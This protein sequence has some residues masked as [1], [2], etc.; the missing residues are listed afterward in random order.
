M[1]LKLDIVTP[2]KQ[3]VSTE[4]DEVVIPGLFGE[5][6]ILLG[7][8]PY[9]GLVRYREGQSLERLAVAEGFAEVG[10]ERVTVLAEQCERPEEI[11]VDRAQ[12]ARNRAEE[13]LA[14]ETTEIN[15]ARA[16][17]ALRRAL[18]RIQVA[19]YGEGH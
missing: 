4:V 6:G 14:G 8:T 13:R 5:M 16:E 18:N 7:H 1:R 12:T 19:A 11:D 2:E 15:L 10:P 3:V 17:A 9:L